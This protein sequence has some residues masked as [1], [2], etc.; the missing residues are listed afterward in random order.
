MGDHTLKVPMSLFRKNRDRLVARLRETPDVPASGA[1]VLLQGGTE[2]PFNDTD[3]NHEFRQV[4]Q[5]RKNI[6][7][8]FFIL[9][10]IVIV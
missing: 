4:T 5:A 9:R 7:G 6:P 8:V 10:K 3:I 2:V 1:V